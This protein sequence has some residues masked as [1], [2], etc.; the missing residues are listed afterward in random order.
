MKRITTQDDVGGFRS[1][2][3]GDVLPDAGVCRGRGGR[4]C[5]LHVCV[6][7]VADPAGGG[8]RAGAD[9]KEVY[10]SLFVGILIGGVFYSG[11]T[12]ELTITHVFQDGIIGSLS[13]AYNVGILVFLVLLGDP[14]LHDEPRPAAPRLLDAGRAS[15]SKAVWAHSLLRSSLEC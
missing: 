7:L 4:V 3:A 9:H 5:A 15:T 14:G 13:D 2:V 10:S 11:F 1:H 6:L 8:D 12:F